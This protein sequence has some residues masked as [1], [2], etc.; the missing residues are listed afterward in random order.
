MPIDT[1]ITS[2]PF[3]D[4]ADE[5]LDERTI[6]PLIIIG[7]SKIDHLLLE[8]L[9]QYLLPKSTKSR[10]PDELLEGDRP[11][12]TFSARTKL[13]YRL[14]LI[15]KSVY[16]AIEKLRALRNPSAHQI[17]FDHTKSPIREHLAEL[18]KYVVNCTSFSLTKSRYF[19]G[20]SLTATEE[21]QCVL[22]TLCVV[23]EAIREKTTTTTGN[24]VSLHIVLK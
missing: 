19:D 11:L 5:L 13:C 12:S 3:D 22:L 20:A 8:I 1:T 21:L 9:K 16:T 23:L 18:R 10:E 15:D 14:G 7:A 4:F 24:R 2:D 6:R 17:T